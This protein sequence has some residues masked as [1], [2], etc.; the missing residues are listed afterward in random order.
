MVCHRCCWKA[1][2]QSSEPGGTDSK[3]V[4]VAF[5][6]NTIVDE[7]AHYD[8]SRDIQVYKKVGVVVMMTNNICSYV[9]TALAGKLAN[10]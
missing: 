2:R 6:G 7:F 1:S 4:K 10:E 8:R 3:P 5:E 9:D